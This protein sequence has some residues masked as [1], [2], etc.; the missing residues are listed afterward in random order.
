MKKQKM[1]T[2]GF[3]TAA[4]ML[5]FAGT[6]FADTAPAAE[7][8]AAGQEEAGAQAVTEGKT[9]P[10]SFGMPYSFPTKGQHPRVMFTEKDIP[11]IRANM[12]NEEG[13]Y[14]MEEL[15]KL[16]AQDVQSIFVRTDMYIQWGSATGQ[17]PPFS[18]FPYGSQYR[19]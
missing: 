16:L 15:K 11:A 12:A 5:S 13:A 1:M 10:A 18:W 6:C 9:L 3:L 14:A 2:T 7:T 19:S 4:L 8:Q 17:E